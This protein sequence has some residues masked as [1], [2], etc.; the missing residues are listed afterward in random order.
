MAPLSDLM[1]LERAREAL[2]LATALDD[3]DINNPK[4]YSIP[5]PGYVCKLW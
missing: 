2:Q 5:P 1:E 4:Q 3:L